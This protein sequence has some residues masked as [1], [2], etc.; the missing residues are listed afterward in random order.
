MSRQTEMFSLEVFK[1]YNRFT[2]SKR[3]GINIVYFMITCVIEHSFKTWKKQK[4]LGN[5]NQDTLSLQILVILGL[6]QRDIK[7]P[8]KNLFK[9]SS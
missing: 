5:V 2:F 8:S 3:L 1:I 7:L 6:F 9:M 4:Q